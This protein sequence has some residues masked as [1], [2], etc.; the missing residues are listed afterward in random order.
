MQNYFSN[1]QKNNVEL[2]FLKIETKTIHVY[3]KITTKNLVFRKIAFSLQTKSNTNQ[4]Y[5]TRKK[6]KKTTNI[7]IKG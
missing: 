1:P 5:N 4:I 6:P 7:L 2:K 3:I